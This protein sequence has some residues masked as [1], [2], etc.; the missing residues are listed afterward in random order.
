MALRSRIFS[1]NPRL[2]SCAVSDPS[3]VTEDDR[4]LHVFLIQQ[5]VRVLDGA[6]IEQGELD[7]FEYGASTADAVL[8]YKQKRKIINPAYQK[9]AD[10]IVGKMT[11]KRLDDEMLRLEAGLLRLG[12]A[13][14]LFRGIAL[15]AAG[16]TVTSGPQVVI[17]SEKKEQFAMWADQVVA[18]FKKNN[19]RIANISVEGAVTPKDV[20]KVYETAASLAGTGG[21]VFINAGHGIPSEVGNA[22]D[23]RLDLAPHQRFM[24]G[25]RDDLLVGE[26]P[27]RNQKDNGIRLHTSVF[28]DEDPDGAGPRPSKKRN[29]ETFNKA[30]PGAKQRLANWA[31]YESICSS[32]K[33]RHLHGVVVLTC[34]VGQSSGMMRKIAQQWGCP[35]IAYP[36]RII[37][38]ITRNFEGKKLVKARSRM[39]CQGDAEGQGTNIPLGEIL[40]RSP[41][42][43]CC[44]GERPPG[45]PRL[46]AV[47]RKLPRPRKALRDHPSRGGA[48]ADPFR[49]FLA[50]AHEDAF[51]R[52]LP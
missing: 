38:E 12:G 25:G 48:V 21:I 18:F 17:V 24:L 26:V 43:W 13:G 7:S 28:Y 20:A 6:D 44:S 27:S 10:N 2:E 30:S 39:F 41:R 19:T 16:K 45:A 46:I 40:S 11:I 1:G 5:A 35:V 32:F 47:L 29:D 23:G 31:A 49:Q 15:L 22:D 33:S 4:G 36:R 50:P 9:Q 14:F 52:I 34:R 51:G 3:H 42:T 8:A 37:G